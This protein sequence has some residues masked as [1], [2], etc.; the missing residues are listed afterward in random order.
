MAGPINTSPGTRPLGPSRPNVAPPGEVSPPAQ[1]KGDPTLGR[2]A[3]L[4]EGRG[5]PSEAVIP[6]LRTVVGNVSL[7]DVLEALEAVP[8]KRT[9][10]DVRKEAD[11]LW[12]MGSGSNNSY[13]RSERDA[14]DVNEALTDP[15]GTP[16]PRDEL[17]AQEALR[18]IRDN[19]E[20]EQAALEELPDSARQQYQ[21][22][23]QGVEHDP[24]A[25]LALQVL[26][27]EGKLSNG[28]KAKDGD[29][30]LTSLHELATNPV[31]KG[32]DRKELLGDVL[33]EI[34]TPSA[35]AQKNRGTCTATTLQIKMAMERPSEY[36][37]LVGGLASPEG[38]VPLANGDTLTREAGT[39]TGQKI[40][41]QYKGKPTMV[42]DMRSVSSQLW[43]PALM[44]YGYG[45]KYDYDNKTDKVSGGAAPNAAF[46]SRMATGLAGEESASVRSWREEGGKKVDNRDAMLDA[47]RQELAH[48]PVAAGLLW[49]E[50]GN[51]GGHEILVTR[52]DADRVYFN[53]PHGL[54]ESM[55]LDEFK[56]RLQGGFIHTANFSG[57]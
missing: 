25:Q 32:I 19:R 31:A 54:E 21:D 12:F 22:L 35:I 20:L 51:Q 27:V 57:E 2:D 45:P 36:A 29:S 8:A 55:A 3:N 34:A 40:Q 42:N 48:R 37:R 33:Q 26:L 56:D 16:I 13:T 50:G 14:L 1:E 38:K 15:F 9:T 43:Q 18:Q 44:Q 5:K 7:D 23:A 4:A 53:N 46:V 6:D 10:A 39:G 52:M 47:L 11:A 30:L 41:V 17:G 24:K 28:P 49:G